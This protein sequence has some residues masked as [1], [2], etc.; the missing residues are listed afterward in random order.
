MQTAS[1]ENGEREKETTHRIIQQFRVPFSIVF[2]FCFYYEKIFGIS[3]SFVLGY[4]CFC[5][6]QT[7][8][9]TEKAYLAPRMMMEEDNGM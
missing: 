4:V 1:R 3:K 5:I 2:L 9:Y 8:E 6:T 7:V